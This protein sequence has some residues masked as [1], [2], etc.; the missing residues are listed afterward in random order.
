MSAELQPNTELEIAHVLFIDVV[1]YSRL[2]INEQS[3]LL[4][5]LNQLVRTTPHFCTAE[6]AGKLIRI[7]VGDGM[8]LVFFT[9]PEAPVL[10]ALEICKALQ[11]HPHIQLRMGIHSGPVDP[12]T[13][14]NDRSNV[15]GAGMN[16]AQR[17]M[18]CADAGHI[19]VSKRVAEDLAHYG[20]WKSRLHDLGEIEVK[21]GTVVSVFNLY[22]EGFGNSQ[23]PTR[24]KKQSR[25]LFPSGGQTPASRR[26]N[27]VRA[28]AFLVLPIAI[29]ISAWAYF[30]N[31]SRGVGGAAFIPQKSI[32]VLP[33]DNFSDDKQDTYFAD[34]I[35]DDI[36][37]ALSKVSDLKVISRNS[38][39]QYREKA[40]NTR[41]IGQALG[42]AHL[43]EGSV[44]RANDKVRITAQLIDARSDQH[45]WA[46]HYDRD[47]A[48][49][50][51]IQSEVAE[52]IAAQLKANISPSEKAAIDVRPTRNLEAFDIYLQAK[53]L[54]NTFHDT[55]DRKETLLKAV[56]LLDEAISRDGNFAL[57]YCLASRANDDLYWFELDHTPAR[58]A[59]AKATAQK[60]LALAPDLGEAHLA[61]AIFYYHGMRDYAQARKE[62]ATA[63]R[64][65]PN[66]AE[67][68]STTGLIDRRQG[69]WDDAVKNLEKAAEL[70]PR[71]SR[72]LG[73]LAIL[74]DLLRRYDEEQAV[75]DRAAAANPASVT[76]FQMMRASI[77]L[78]KG[79]TK[80]ARSELDSL[81]TGYDPAG[82]VTFTRISL[83]LYERDPP[84]AEKILAAS[85][86]EEIVGGTGSLL[87]RSW[88]EALIA[89]AQGNAQK[90]REAFAAAREKTEAKLRDH[91]DDGILVAQ[92][93][94]I[95]AGLQRK[96]EAIAEGLRAVELRPISSD[97]VDG[98]TV[99][100]SVAMIYAWVGD[101]DPAIERLTSL[102]KMPGGPD[103]GQLKLDPAWDAVRRDPR[104]AK[105]LDRLRP[106]S[107]PR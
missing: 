34:G 88:F 14:V 36:L 104:F 50:F 97:A 28:V 61:Q 102:A 48:D 63:Q 96:Q 83:A 7:P 40:R 27:A 85:N 29:G 76:Y 13:D 71:N 54:I 52:N 25:R 51:A 37:T 75:F 56:R 80:T 4:A 91:P 24:I 39:M 21:H 15:A 47:L 107:N 67:I 53:Q 46:E 38:V 45:V 74:Y 70:D 90:A 101:V 84:A 22:G 93:G 99:L 2:L 20:H 92:L 68:F 78:E 106:A 43:L 8:A 10:C 94:L 35:Q 9:S 69:R 100:S 58:L 16:V 87:P 60:A 105:M 77:E 72:I 17:I 89:R 55:P 26:R 98:A 11:E 86:L 32:A 23:V 64:F 49:V 59:Q 65:L 31:P 44:R 18:D 73:D 6:A 33:F 5:E 103:Y 81:P 62:L 57:A 79:N 3:A 95:D 41:E 19:L 42:V 82:A 12:V 66:D 1:G 30:R